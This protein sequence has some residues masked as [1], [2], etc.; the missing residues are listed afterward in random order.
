LTP[1][2]APDGPALL[3]VGRIEKP[4]GLRGEVVVKLTSNVAE[5]VDPG[6]VLFT[7][8]AGGRALEIEASRPHQQRHIVAFAG[9]RSREDAETLHGTTLYAEPVDDDDPDTLWIHELIGA[10]VV[11][12]TARGDERPRGT[13][14]SVIDNPAADILELDGGALVPLNFVVASEPGRV[15][16][17][18]PAGLFPEDEPDGADGAPA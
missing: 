15:V 18:V 16:V 3:E 17:E 10:S 12:R 6:S 13:V 9:V 8:A 7:A 1:P 14:R 4:H 5:R 2:A 11:E